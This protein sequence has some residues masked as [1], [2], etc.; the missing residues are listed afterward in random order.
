MIRK[1]TKMVKLN[2]LYSIYA[3]DEFCNEFDWSVDDLSFHGYT[4]LVVYASD[5]DECPYMVIHCGDFNTPCELE[6]GDICNYTPHWYVVGAK[7]DYEIPADG[8]QLE[9]LFKK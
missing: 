4:P 8:H 9:W 1:G 5:I 2:G 3:V 7:T 6:N